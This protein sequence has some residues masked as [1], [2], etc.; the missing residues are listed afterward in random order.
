MDNDQNLP[1][2]L[3][4]C[5]GKTPKISKLAYIHPDATIIGNVEIG[6][7]S[8]IWGGVIIRGDDSKITIGNRTNIQENTTIHTPY[9]FKVKIGDNVTVAHGSVVHGCELED[10]TCISVGGVV[11]DGASIGTGSVVDTR[12]FVTEN[13]RIPPRTL[14]HGNPGRPVRVITD[15]ELKQIKLWAEW[16]VQKIQNQ[17]Q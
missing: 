2:N 8:S 3:V 11:F 5:N 15:R 14:V 6:D 13:V 7:Y 4:E 1:L 9:N 17:N 16:Y 12:A 10:L